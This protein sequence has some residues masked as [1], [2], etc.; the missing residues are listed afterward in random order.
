MSLSVVLAQSGLCEFEFIQLWNLRPGTC[1]EARALV[2]TL[3][4]TC[5]SNEQLQ[6]VIDEIKKSSGSQPSLNGDDKYGPYDNR[7]DDFF[8]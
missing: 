2:P 4:H 3:L 8:D 1:D 5:P 6:Q 7:K